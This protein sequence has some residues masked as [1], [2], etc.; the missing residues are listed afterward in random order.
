MSI[1]YNHSETYRPTES[2][3]AS[4]LATAM[5]RVYGL[6]AVGLA[7]TAIVAWITA[8]S[9]TILQL[10]FGNTIVFWGLLI[11]EL[12]L[13]IAIGRA[14]NKLS[15]TAATALFLFY[16][17]LNGLTL[18]AV[19]LVY[20]LSSIALA[21]VATSSLFAAMSIIGY[22]TKRDMSKMGGF[23]LM[24]LIGLIIASVVNFFLASSALEWVLTYAG[25][26][27]FLGLT[28]YHTQRIKQ[29]TAAMLLSGQPEMVNRVA[30]MGALSLYL[31][32]I[33]LFLYLLRLIGRRR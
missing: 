28:V 27:I 7:L 26:A 17:A 25:I 21:F 24:A 18:A 12:V 13:V 8:H 5:T 9:A 20:T 31:D 19:F 4:A 1:Q 33:N 22:T 2:Q 6:M 30:I 16:A 3:L 32:F 23:L 11:G 29:G 10:I 14:I 15:P